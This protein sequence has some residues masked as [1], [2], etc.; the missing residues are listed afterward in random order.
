VHLA[1]VQMARPD[2][3]LVF[4]VEPQVARATR[5]RVFDWAATERLRVAGA[6]LGFPGFGHVVRA[7][8]GFAYAPET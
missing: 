1:S 3:T 7:G 2:A 4:D 8:N 5:E 6:H